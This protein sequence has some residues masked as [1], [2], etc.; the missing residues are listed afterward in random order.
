[1]VKRG[2]ANNK[3]ICEKQVSPLCGS[4]RKHVLTAIHYGG[5]LRGEWYACYKVSFFRRFSTKIEDPLVKK[6]C[7]AQPQR[8]L[9]NKFIFPSP[10]TLWAWL[11]VT[12]AWILAGWQIK[13]D[14]FAGRGGSTLLRVGLTGRGEWAP[15]LFSKKTL[16]LRNS[17]KVWV[18]ERGGGYVEIIN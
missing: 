8:G 10:P 15:P 11:L 12:H 2:I 7:F 5:Y 13:C 4:S 3:S 6:F 14:I 9:L 16:F 1:M 17:G 18:E